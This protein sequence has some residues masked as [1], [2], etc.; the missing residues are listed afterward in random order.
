MLLTFNIHVMSFQLKNPK[1]EKIGVDHV[2]DGKKYA[3]HFT[4]NEVTKL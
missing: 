3:T 1:D 4:L 2:R